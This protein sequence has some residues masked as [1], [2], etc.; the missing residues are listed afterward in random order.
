MVVPWQA[1]D[2]VAVQVVDTLPVVGKPGVCKRT[3][4]GTRA[5]VG[6]RVVAGTSLVVAGM[7]PVVV[8]MPPVVA[9]TRTVWRPVADKHCW[10]VRLAPEP[11]VGWVD[12]FPVVYRLAA[13][14][15]FVVE[16]CTWR[17]LLV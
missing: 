11:V 3:E 12:F 9:G 8:G 17:T 13:T 4:A 6:T 2:T 1:I 15:G 7:Q 5:V 16:I 10:P 14:V